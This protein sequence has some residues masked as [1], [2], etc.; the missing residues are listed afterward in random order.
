MKRTPR[1]RHGPVG[2]RYDCDRATGQRNH[3]KYRGGSPPLRPTAAPASSASRR[4]GE[5]PAAATPRRRMPRGF[6]AVLDA[7]VRVQLRNASH[8][9]KQYVN[10]R[11]IQSCACLRIMLALLRNLAGRASIF[12]AHL[13]GCA[14]G[15]STRPRRVATTST[16]NQARNAIT[17]DK[18]RSGMAPGWTKHRRAVWHAITV[19]LCRA[20]QKLYSRVAGRWRPHARFLP[21][22]QVRRGQ[23]AVAPSPTACCQAL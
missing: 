12:A 9:W 7:A 5:L 3:I 14:P 22:R 10:C 13:A 21:A 4:H 20:R 23:W 19:R 6:A 2:P 16:P 8:R 15:L 1:P 11:A 17:Q 18:E